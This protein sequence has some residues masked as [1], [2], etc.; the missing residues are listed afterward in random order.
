MGLPFPTMT[1]G[2]FN[3]WFGRMANSLDFLAENLYWDAINSMFAEHPV[4]V[5]PEFTITLLRYTFSWRDRDKRLPEW[6]KLRDRAALE[7]KERGLCA[8][9]L[10]RGLYD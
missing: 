6:K 3:A 4:I 2:S 5:P 1:V 7:F 8:E 9:S 10:L